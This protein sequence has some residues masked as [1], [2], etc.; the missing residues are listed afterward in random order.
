MDNKVNTYLQALRKIFLSL[1]WL[2][3]VKQKGT[4]H[5]PSEFLQFHLKEAQVLD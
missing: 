5:F 3:E 1:Y 4:L 2:Q